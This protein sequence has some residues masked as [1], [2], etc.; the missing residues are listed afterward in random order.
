MVAHRVLQNALEQHG[1][2]FGR[3]MAVAFRKL[4]H[5]FL[6]DVKR[7]IFVAQGELHLAEGPAFYGSKKIGKF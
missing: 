6:H 5:G 3:T 7:S 2:L 1:E 4:E